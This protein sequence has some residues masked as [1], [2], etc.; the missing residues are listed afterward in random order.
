[1]FWA[2]FGHNRRTGLV[3]LDRDPQA[4]RNGVTSRVIQALYEAFLPEVVVEGGEF[5]HDSA[6]PHRGNI[7][8]QLLEEM[9]IRVMEWPPYSPDLN[10][11]E[12][13]WALVKAELYRLHPELEHAEDTDATL[14][15]LIRGAQEAWHNID[16]GILYRLATTIEDRVQAVIASGGWYTKY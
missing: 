12:N 3:P 11:I 7:V 13:L 9:A 16:I 10:P 1:M 14:N 8:K 6:G 4:A 2:A 15:A 5:I